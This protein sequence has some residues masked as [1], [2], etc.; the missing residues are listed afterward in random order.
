MQPSSLQPFIYLVFLFTHLKSVLAIR[1]IFA[2]RIRFPQPLSCIRTRER[3]PSCKDPINS[4]KNATFEK[5]KSRKKNR[6][7]IS[8][9]QQRLFRSSAERRMAVVK[10]LT[11]RFRL[12]AVAWRERKVSFKGRIVKT[13]RISAREL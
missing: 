13:P 8:L 10:S 7:Q 11:A 4:P 9:Y 2:S 5:K 6:K 12:R 1:S 3:K